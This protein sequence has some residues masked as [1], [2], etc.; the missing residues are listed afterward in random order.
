M[1]VF[2]AAAANLAKAY[3]TLP[4]ASGFA[5]RERVVIQAKHWRAKSVDSA[6]ILD[7]VSRLS[8]WEPPHIH[9]LVVATSGRF[10]P[11]AVRFIE[12]HNDKGSD[13]RIEPWP[14]THLEAMLA[15]RPE[16]TAAYGL[17]G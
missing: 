16:L 8:A 5:R 12:S 2:D 9:S 1:S 7:V 4:D 15:R 11:D 10:T 6:S 13:P 14:E 17:R 3:R